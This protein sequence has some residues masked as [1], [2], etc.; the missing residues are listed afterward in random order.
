MKEEKKVVEVEVEVEVEAKEEVSCLGVLVV[1]G[2]K[3][4]AD[5]LVSESRRKED[6]EIKRNLLTHRQ[7]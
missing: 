3:S 5:D 2:L 1:L 7:R 4:E 6:Q